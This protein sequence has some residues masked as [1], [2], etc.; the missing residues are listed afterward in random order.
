MNAAFVAAALAAAP[1]PTNYDLIRAEAVLHGPEDDEVLVVEPRLASALRTVAV[2]LEVMDPREARY[3]G[4]GVAPGVEV[5]MLRARVL[6]LKDAPSIGAA[7]RLP[8]VVTIQEGLE[9]ARGYRDFLL[10]R[11]AWEADR[12]SLLVAAAA[13]Q[14]SL[15][16]FWNDAQMAKSEVYYLSARRAAL[17]RVRDRM[18]SDRFAAGQWPDFVPAWSFSPR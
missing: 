7:E 2:R 4:F 1:I 18:G 13:E 17:G 8:S 11:A 6:A 14:Q 12:E 15:I 10:D 9:F 3:Y 5:N 16:D